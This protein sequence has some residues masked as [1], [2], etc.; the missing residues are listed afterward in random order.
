[1]RTKEQ[2]IWLDQEIYL[3]FLQGDEEPRLMWYAELSNVNIGKSMGSTW[4]CSYCRSTVPAS[5]LKCEACNAPRKTR[6][7][8]AEALLTGVL[9]ELVWFD[10]ARDGFTLE[11]KRYQW[12]RPDWYDHGTPIAKLVNCKVVEKNIPILMVGRKYEGEPAL[13]LELDVLLE[14]DFS[15]ADAEYEDADDE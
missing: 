9:S 5:S 4:E 3:W 2:D 7:R 15:F 14:G 11:A 10:A 8:R 6:K 1:M 13:P 12:G